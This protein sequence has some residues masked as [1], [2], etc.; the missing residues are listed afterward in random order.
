MK[1]G[2]I[3]GVRALVKWAHYNAAVVEGYAIK[4]S[5]TGQWSLR[6]T[7]VMTDAYKL[8]KRPL[9]FVALHEKGEWRW[10]IVDFELHGGALRAQLGA[11]EETSQYGAVAIR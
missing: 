11:P 1:V 3:R 9:I 4:I 5:E 6:A 10:P 8:S 2:H 7:V